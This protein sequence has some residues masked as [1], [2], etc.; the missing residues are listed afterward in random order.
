MSTLPPGK[1]ICP[2]WFGRWAERSVSSTVGSERAI[3]GISTAA[4]RI[5]AL[6]TSARSSG[7]RSWSPA[8]A[9]PDGARMQARARPLEEVGEAGGRGGGRRHEGGHQDISSAAAGTIGKKAP[10]EATP[11]IALP[12][13]LPHLAKGSKIECEGRR[14]AR[15]KVA[16]YM[17]IGTQAIGRAVDLEAQRMVDIAI[18]KVIE[19][20]AENQADSLVYFLAR[21]V[22]G[23]ERRIF[24]GNAHLLHRRDQ[25]VALALALQHGGEQAHHGWTI[26]RRSGIEPRSVA[27]DS[28]VNFA[29]IRR[30]PA[31]QRWQAASIHGL[32]GA[33]QFLKSRRNAWIH[34]SF[35][36]TQA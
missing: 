36:F 33:H 32:R 35:R 13:Y 16:A 5:A 18:D 6:S 1:A 29:A 7:M 17:Y 31:L 34:R 21:H 10:A 4:S 28:H 9:S 26:D 25:H 2:A 15:P 14:E 3:T 30:I 11:N 23:E 20:G 24:D 22:D 19:I 12:L 27:P 8:R